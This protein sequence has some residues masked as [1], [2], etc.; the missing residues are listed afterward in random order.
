M[1]V[2]R[3]CGRDG[4]RGNR[5]G[6]ERGRRRG[7]ERGVEEGEGDR[8]TDGVFVCGGGGGRYEVGAVG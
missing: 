4:G 7:G 1:H 8:Q 2:L 3:A 5:G 6:G